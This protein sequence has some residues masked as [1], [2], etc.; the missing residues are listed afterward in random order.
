MTKTEELRDLYDTKIRPGLDK[1]AIELA[2]YLWEEITYSLVGETTPDATELIE[3]VNSHHRVDEILYYLVMQGFSWDDGVQG[4]EMMHFWS[5]MHD[6][7]DCGM[8]K[9]GFKEIAEEFPEI[10]LTPPR[11]LKPA[12]ETLLI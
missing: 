10:K 6:W 4:E 9:K 12:K 2:D 1:H 3:I 11:K 8:P 5:R 7:C